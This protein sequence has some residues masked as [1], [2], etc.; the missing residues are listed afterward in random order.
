MKGYIKSIVIIGLILGNLGANVVAIAAEK[1]TR[2]PG[3]ASVLEGSSVAEVASTPEAAGTPEVASESESAH[4]LAE[5]RTSE[6]V[7]P[8]TTEQQL[9]QAGKHYK[10]IPDRVRGHEDVKQ[11]S[12]A[13]PGKVQVIMFFSYAC[14]WC[15]QL[16]KPFD[17]WSLRQTDNVKAYMLPVAFNRAWLVLAKGFFTAQTLDHTGALDDAIFAAIHQQGMPLWQEKKLEDFCVA[18]G[19]EREKFNQIFNSFDVDSKV[20]RADELSLAFEID[21]TPNIIVNGPKGAYITNLVM[22]KD[23]DVLLEVVDHLV[24]KAMN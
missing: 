5:T 20:K 21:A 10:K 3:V 1:D 11:L 8:S 19:V 9:F 15:S 13:D 14:Y 4:S 2:G 12:H 22:N 24:Q 17:N 18:H 23:K 16:N 7:P 6:N